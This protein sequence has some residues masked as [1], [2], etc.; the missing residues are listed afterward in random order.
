MDARIKIIGSSHIARES[1]ENVKK[2]IKEFSPDIIALELDRKRLYA[3]LHKKQ[4][5][6]YL[7]SIRRVGVKGFLFSLIGSIAQKKLGRI[8]NVEPGSEMKTAFAIAKRNNIRVI[9]IDQDIEVTLKKFSMAITWREK[10][11]FLLDIL[12]AILGI[13]PELKFDLRTVPDEK[14]I[15]ILMQEIGRAHV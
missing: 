8:V 5:P 11:N 2:H 10:W 6:S 12:K 14:I 4:K 13:R 1:I 3:M 15:G 7:A 9:L